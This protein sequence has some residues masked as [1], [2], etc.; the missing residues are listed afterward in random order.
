M[1]KILPGLYRGM[2][3]ETAAPVIAGI[4]SATWGRGSWRPVADELSRPVA[5]ECPGRARDE[6]SRAGHGVVGRDRT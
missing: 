4:H 3:V 2:N 6:L 5:D 1:P